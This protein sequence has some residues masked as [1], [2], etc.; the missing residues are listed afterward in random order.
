MEPQHPDAGAPAGSEG[1]P[2]A[3]LALLAPAAVV[4]SLTGSL[5]PVAPEA[6]AEAA[7]APASVAPAAVEAPAPAS[8]GPEVNAS[9]AGSAPAP[10]QS[11]AAASTSVPAPPLAADAAARVPDSPWQAPSSLEAAPSVLSSE[12]RRYGVADLPP[13]ARELFEAIRL[14]D[15]LLAQKG[16]TCQQLRWGLDA[17]T[18]ELGQRLRSVEPLPEL[19]GSPHP[20]SARADGTA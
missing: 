9:A 2:P 6:D 13:D 16:A 17:F 8:P 12:G 3:L 4:D 18:R 7:G 20:G 11:G 5:L 1:S 10:V 15:R 19:L 14:A